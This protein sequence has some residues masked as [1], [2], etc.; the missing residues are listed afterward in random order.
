MSN[1]DEFKN[2]NINEIDFEENFEDVNDVKVSN[3]EFEAELKDDFETG[4]EDN[5][6]FDKNDSGLEN[7]LAERFYEII[8]EDFESESELDDRIDNLLIEP[9]RQFLFGGL[10]KLVSKASKGIKNLT[11][12]K[13]L[14]AVA[15]S[16]LNLAKSQFPG[17]DTAL[18]VATKLA[19]GNTKGLVGSLF[20]GGL[21]KAGLNF[22]PG[23]GFVN[24]AL[25]L[26]KSAGVNFAIPSGPEGAKDFA[27]DLSFIANN[28]FQ[29]LA[30]NIM[31]PT[32]DDLQNPLVAMRL[33]QKSVIDALRQASS[34][35]RTFRPA[36]AMNGLNLPKQF[37]SN[38]LS[39]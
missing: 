23:G 11:K 33:A 24:S 38:P 22:V 25:P 27:N 10:K 28:S 19:S 32:N 29:N 5:F 26:L 13:I 37:A 35:G 2:E 20:K 6:E 31:S 12:N 39:Y 17:L 18:N 16:G 8:Q 1:Y 34:M 15:K 9:E 4:M 36:Y 3:N 21:L 7:Q 30:S 14:R